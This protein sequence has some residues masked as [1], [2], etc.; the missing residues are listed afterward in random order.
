MDVNDADDDVITG[1][2]TQNGSSA[3]AVTRTSG[4]KMTCQLFLFSLQ[5]DVSPCHQ[6]LC[7]RV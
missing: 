7:L 5:H 6:N 1:A 3:V 2:C 4:L